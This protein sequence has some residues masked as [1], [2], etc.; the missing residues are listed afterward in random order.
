MP[1]RPLETEDV[2]FPLDAKKQVTV[3]KYNNT[4]LIDI[5]EFY[6][7]SD[8]NKKPGKKGIALTEESWNKLVSS[9]DDINAAIDQIS[10]K[11]KK[12]EKDEKDEKEEKKEKDDVKSDE[13]EEVNNVKVKGEEED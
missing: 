2:T 9:M 6:T 5:R 7:D 10:G 12:D 1:K 4:T 13:V 8:N 11:K 3:R